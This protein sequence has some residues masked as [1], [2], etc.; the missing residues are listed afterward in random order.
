MRRC[1]TEPS[2]RPDSQFKK[3]A[4]NVVINGIK[5]FFQELTKQP[6]KRSW[7]KLTKA[8]K[9]SADCMY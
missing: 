5:I 6:H 1:S 3:K 2:L 4:Y 8:I 7:Q 9:P